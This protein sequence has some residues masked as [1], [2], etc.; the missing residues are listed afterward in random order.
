MITGPSCVLGPVGPA[1]CIGSVAKSAA[2]GAAGSAFNAIAHEFGKLAQHTTTW[3]WSTMG[4]ATAIRFGGPGWQRDLGI[5]F[6]LAMVVAA[7]LFLLQVISSALK[8]DASGLGRALRGLLIAGVGS[9][10]AIAVTETL[11]A[12]TDTLANGI[13]VAGT[14][15]ATWTGLGNKLVDVSAMPAAL[16]PAATL[17]VSLFVIAASV[18]VWGALMVRKLLL[19]VTAVFAPV[20]MA[21]SVFGPTAGWVR[22]WVELTAALIASKIILVMIFV[23]G[24]GVLGTST[25]QP[26]HAGLASHVTTLT[27]GCLILCLAG[28]A[29]WFAIKLVHF[30]GDSFHTIHAHA[31][32]VTG[33]GQSAIAAPQKLASHAQTVGRYGAIAPAAVANGAAPIGGTPKASGDKPAQEPPQQVSPPPGRPALNGTTPLNPNGNRQA[34]KPTPQV[35]PQ[36][37]PPNKETTE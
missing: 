14:G 35:N 10:G 36:P 9:F 26:A 33:A 15:Q 1:S 29:P 21:G 37:P 17:I 13:M 8:R 22:K 31:V 12:A 3:L 6:G 24:L 20:A 28:F 16:G 25:A 7:G 19:I 11:L 32:S 23:I 30:A 18:V 4:S 27:T 34:P 2:A 5:T